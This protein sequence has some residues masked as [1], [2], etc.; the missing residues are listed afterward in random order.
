MRNKKIKILIVNPSSKLGGGN[1]ISNSLAIGLDKNIFEIF[2]FFPEKGPAVSILEKENIPVLISPKTELFSI[3]AFLH[4]FL[5]ENKMDIVH[6]QGT[7]T[8]FWVKLVFLFLKDRPKFVYT[9]HGFHIAYRPSWQKYLLLLLEKTTNT[10][11][12][13]LICPSL[14]VKSLAEKYK[15]INNSKI[16]L[17]Y[18]GIDIQKFESAKPLDKKNL[19]IPENYLIISAIQRLEFPKDVATILDAFEIV[20]NSFPNVF[21]II[22]GSGSLKEKLQKKAKELKASEHILFLGDRLDIPNILISSDVVILSSA[23]EALGLSLIE[24][25]A[26]RK[27]V[28]G[29][30]V[31]GI[32]EII[33]HGENGF[34]V[35]FRNKEE[36]AKFILILLNDPEIRRKMGQNGFE[37]TKT[38]FSLEKM[39]KNYQ[40]LYISILK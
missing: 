18:N 16:E 32:K 39:I 1:T 38:K 10:L 11:V 27:P 17:I 14:S 13:F 7:R 34:L 15:I 29:T 19:N 37:F 26:A 4:N 21:L 28:I 20:R 9:L 12:D 24:A 3:L 5:R 33:K 22:V 35:E 40:D 30:K 2:S 23:F 31:D 8:A 36:M 25:M 6:A